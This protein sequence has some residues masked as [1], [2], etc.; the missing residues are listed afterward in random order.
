MGLPVEGICQKF[1]K[2]EDLAKIKQNLYLQKAD[3]FYYKP[4]IW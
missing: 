2:Q 3:L 4:I 1:G